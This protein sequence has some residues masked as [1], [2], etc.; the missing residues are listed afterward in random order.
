MSLSVIPLSVNEEVRQGWAELLS[1]VAWDWFATLTWRRG[2]G[3][4]FESCLRNFRGWL[5]GCL[6]DEALRVGLAERSEDGRGGV[7]GAWP[8]AYRARKRW[9]LPVWVIGLEPHGDGVLHLHG[10]V[11][12][13]AKLQRASRRHAWSSWFER[14]GINRI[15]PPKSPADV[16]GYVS[17]YVVKDGEIVLS[18]SFDA[19]AFRVG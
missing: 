17:K 6:Q 12:L 13:P 19:P 11:R 16:A 1:R 10:L 5:Y 4:G 2:V 9:A 7:R 3:V 18:E 15:E 14:H 8:N